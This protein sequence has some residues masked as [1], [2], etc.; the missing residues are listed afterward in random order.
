MG[1]EHLSWRSGGVLDRPDL[2]LG[3]GWQSNIVMDG[4]SDNPR[5]LGPYFAL[6][7]LA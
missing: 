6:R 2:A 1:W 4:R 5:F 7:A 3:F